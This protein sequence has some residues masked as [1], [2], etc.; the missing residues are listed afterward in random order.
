MKR[1]IGIGTGGSA[2]V[3]LD[4]LRENRDIYIVG[5]VDDDI[6][7]HGTFLEGI[8]IIGDIN[9]LSGLREQYDK[10]LICIGAKRDTQNRDRIFKLV[11]AMGFQVVSLISRHSLISSFVNIGEG[12][13]IMSGVTINCGSVIDD[14][15]FLNTGTVVEHDCSIGRS[16]FLGPGCVVSGDVHISDNS[17]IGSGTVISG[18]VKVGSGVTLGAGSVV[19]RDMPNN[20]IAYG[21]PCHQNMKSIKGIEL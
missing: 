11:K 13:I 21:N 17:F 10:V 1:V 12:C 19:V 15:A 18:S 14:N 9:D 4:I 16:C 8:Q 7:K 6:L 3:I 2:R 5:F 20:V